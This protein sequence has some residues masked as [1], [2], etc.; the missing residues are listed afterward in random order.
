MYQID[1]TVFQNGVFPLP[2]QV[3]DALPLLSPMLLKA[4]VWIPLFAPLP[5]IWRKS[6]A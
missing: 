1:P 5:P 4:A 6:S 2:V 3:A